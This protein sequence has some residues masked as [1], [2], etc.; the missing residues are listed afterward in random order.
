[1]S[2]GLLRRTVFLSLFAFSFCFGQDKQASPEG[3]SFALGGILGDH[4]WGGGTVK[5]WFTDALAVD[6]SV[7]YRWGLHL[8]ASFTHNKEYFDFPKGDMMLSFGGGLWTEIGFGFQMGLQGKVGAEWFMPWAPWG[9]FV[10][11]F[12]L[13]ILCIY[14]GDL[15]MRGLQARGFIS[16]LKKK[17]VYG[18]IF[19]PFWVKIL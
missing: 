13:S 5:Y 1:M 19:Q 18:R 11:I 15:F 10:I 6:G 17:C 3:G 16:D 12:Q 7:G 4:P 2:A 8:Q 14:V 9:V